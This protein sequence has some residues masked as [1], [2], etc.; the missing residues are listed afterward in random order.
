[1]NVTDFTSGVESVRLSYHPNTSVWFD[2]PMTFNSTT[3][4]YEYIIPGQHTDTL[5]KYGI[6]AYDN[7]GNYKADDNN[8]QYYV[9]TVIPEFESL[10]ILQL[11]MI[12]TLLTVIIYR[13]SGL[14]V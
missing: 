8:G 11:F 13:K 2:F 14:R 9:Y 7:A 6:A 4:L 5:V 3:V 12:A 10:V 1:V